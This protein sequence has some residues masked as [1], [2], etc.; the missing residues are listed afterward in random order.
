MSTWLLQRFV[1]NDLKSVCLKTCYMISVLRLLITF[2]IYHQVYKNLTTFL[3]IINLFNLE[4]E[5]VMAEEIYSS[6]PSDRTLERAS[7]N[8]GQNHPSS[9]LSFVTSTVSSL[10]WGITSPKSPR[11]WFF[12]ICWI[13][14]LSWM[15][16]LSPRVLVINHDI[17]HKERLKG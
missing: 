13:F 17:K 2:I 14:S 3:S 11:K 9:S 16:I 8:Y 1:D 10:L 12:S 4:W 6:S 15:V 5:S 7:A